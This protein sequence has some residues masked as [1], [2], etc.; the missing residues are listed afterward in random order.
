M[1]PTQDCEAEGALSFKPNN[2]KQARLA[3]KVADV[4]RPKK[5]KSSRGRHKA[6]MP[7][8]KYR[9][10]CPVE[11]KSGKQAELITHQHTCD[12]GNGFLCAGECKVGDNQP[13][14]DCEIAANKLVA[15][16]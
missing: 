12:C 3:I 11:R 16:G 9:H 1:K 14:E 4:R 10:N 6:K 13:C 2:R 15:Q 5:A 8:A 7:L